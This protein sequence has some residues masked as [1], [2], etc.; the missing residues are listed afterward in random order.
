MKA[1]VLFLASVISVS[2]FATKKPKNAKEPNDIRCETSDE[3]E[4]AGTTMI[5]IN[6]NQVL[7][8]EDNTAATARSFRATM[9]NR[10]LD[11]DIV[12]DVNAGTWEGERLATVPY[13]GKKYVGYVKFDLSHHTFESTGY[14][15]EKAHLILSPKYTVVK[16]IPMK[17]NH[18]QTWTWDIE[19][20]KH[21]AVLDAN[22]DDHHGDYIPMNCYS[23]ERVNDSKGRN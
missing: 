13:K 19:V 18:D 4:F 20:R 10:N 23:T 3:H 14:N 16:T 21:P 7:F 1:L 6:L 11:Y 2:A 12:P 9:V 22:Y 15:P 8:N 5:Y 17:N